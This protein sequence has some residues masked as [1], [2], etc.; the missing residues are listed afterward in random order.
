MRPF[1][2][3]ICCLFIQTATAG[4]RTTMIT[5]I[6]FD[7]V[8]SYVVL[9]VRINTSTPLRFILDSGLSNTLITEMYP[10]DS[11]SLPFSDTLTIKGLGAGRK[12]E[13]LV[14]QGNTLE[15]GRMRFVNQRVHLL[16]EDLFNLSALTG[17]PINGL[18]GSDFFQDHVVQIDYVKR[19]INFYESS[20]FE[21]PKGFVAVPLVIKQ[22]KMYTQLLVKQAGDKP[23]K[24]MVLLD[25][26]AELTAWL[27]LQG[28]GGLR[29]PEK[30]LEGYIGEGLNGPITGHFGRIP[31]LFVG[32]WKLDKPVVSFPDSSCI[33]D[34]L[35]DESR[36]GTLGSQALTRFHLIFDEPNEL[37]YIK[38][39]HLH[40]KPFGYNVSGMDIHKQRQAPFLPHIYHVRLG[41]PA[42]EAGVREGDFLLEADGMSGFSTDITLLRGILETPRRAPVSMTVLRENK[43]LDLSVTMKDELAD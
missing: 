19:R 17:Q 33:A 6:P 43:T 24:V 4:N 14:S 22:Q 34:M 36:E 39:N 15:V 38:P 7:L 20:S 13:A 29:L 42:Y 2:I 9:T 37:M 40:K 26:G 31:G 28:Q 8:G 32:G 12:V 1:F 27:H 3:A 41:S 23:R 11:L 30:T 35:K 10:S 16:M 21:A 18:L 5:S 25:T